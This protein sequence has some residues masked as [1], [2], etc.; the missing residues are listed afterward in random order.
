MTE[1]KSIS[2][3]KEVLQWGGLAAIVGILYFTGWHTQVSGFLQR[4]ILWTGFIQA[5]TE[6]AESEQVEVDYDMPLITLDGE[7]TNLEEFKGKV[8][9]LNFWATWCPPCIAEMPSIQKVYESY[10][11]NNDIAFI[12]INLDEDIQK[13][14]DYLENNGYSFGS[15]QLNG[16]TPLAFRSSIIPTTF[17]VNKEGILVVKKRGMANYNTDAFRSFID[18]LLEN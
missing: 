16:G 5:N 11:G 14:R 15:Y 1:K 2:W 17:V 10:A 8:V 3:K 6:L 13:A 12:M 4:G 7:R 9:F 18:T